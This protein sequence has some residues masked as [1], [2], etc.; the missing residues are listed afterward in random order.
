M[1]QENKVKALADSS[2][3]FRVLSWKGMPYLECLSW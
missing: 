2:N 1:K 3:K